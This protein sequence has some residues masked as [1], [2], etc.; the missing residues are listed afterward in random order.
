MGA[1][2][3]RARPD[4]EELAKI[5]GISVKPSTEGEA[6]IPPRFERQLR[7]ASQRRRGTETPWVAVVKVN[8]VAEIREE[9]GDPAAEEFLRSTAS[10]LRAGLRESDKLAPVGRE[11]YGIILDAPRGDEAVAG[12]ERL[13][14]GVRELSSRDRRWEGGSLSIG[15]APLWNDG[16]ATILDRARR[17]LERAQKHGGGI[18]MMAA[19]T[20]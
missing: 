12:L 15:V 14:R 3:Q 20:R 5:I 8:G 16:P 7:G 10:T 19:E 1:P 9:H 11:E 6:T 18:V 17:A 13:V 4:G 2:S